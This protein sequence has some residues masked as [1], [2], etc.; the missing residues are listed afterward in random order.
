MKIANKIILL[1]VFLLCVLGANTWVG[2][3][4]MANIRSEFA[5]MADYDVVLMEAV[6]SIHQLQLQKNV[7]LQR[8]IGIAEE[9]GF[10]KVPFAR[11]SYLK[12]QLKVIQ[13]GMDQ[14]AQ[15]GARET[16][17]ARRTAAQ[18]FD[19][20]VGE[21]QRGPLRE[22]ME[23]LNR[24]ESARR[25]YDASIAAILASV[26]AGGFQLSLEDLENIQRQENA[27][28]KDVEDLLKRVQAFSRDSLLRTG[29]WEAQAQRVLL[30]SLLITV[31]V[32]CLLAW[33]LVQ[34]IV[35]PLRSLDA[36]ARQVGTGNFKVNLSAASKDELADLARAFN[37][38]SAQL[39]EFKARLEKQ[40][41]DLK[42]ANEELDK[43]IHIM[44]HDIVDPLTMMIG[45]CA[46]VEAHANGLDPKSL[47]ALQGIRRAS[48]KMHQMVKD[49]LQFTKSKRLENPLNTPAK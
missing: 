33:W 42:S 13:E 41:R 26:E 36:A 8:T 28:S 5:A 37:A 35:R 46:Y 47:E 23:G 19:V 15:A 10:E 44:G 49:L 14:Y 34:S 45:Y 39:E 1:I 40:N 20:A 7:L 24:L 29:Q 3:R 12:D 2:V 27:L 32:G 18:A 9:L 22:A 11:V 4:Q 16:L 31:I 30:W 17:R 6:T 25:Q 38:M 48:T 21:E 43:F